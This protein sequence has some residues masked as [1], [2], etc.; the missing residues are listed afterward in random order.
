MIVEHRVEDVLSIHPDN[1]LYLENGEQVYY[2]AVD[3]LLQVVDYHHIKL[4][5]TTIFERAKNE[6][7]PFSNP[8]YNPPRI[9]IH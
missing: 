2:G 5:A 9:R 3:G 6:P 1:V 4:P 7:P 8:A